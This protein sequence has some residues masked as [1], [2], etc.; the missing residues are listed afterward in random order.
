MSKLHLIKEPCGRC[1]RRL[2]GQSSNSYQTLFYN[3][4]ILI[5]GE[6]VCWGRI[7]LYICNLLLSCLY[8]LFF[9][10]PNP[11]DEEE[12]G[13]QAEA[14]PICD[15]TVPYGELLKPRGMAYKF[16]RISVQVPFGTDGIV[17]HDEDTFFAAEYGFQ[18]HFIS[19]IGFHCV[20][21]VQIRERHEAKGNVPLLRQGAESPQFLPI[22]RHQL[23]PLP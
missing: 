13:Q 14:M 10:F 7:Y 5:S 15:P 16:G 9:F 1:F 20:S 18:G 11:C 6:W 21:F 2:G 4:W 17:F 3:G 22:L 19:V 12:S 23:F 8:G